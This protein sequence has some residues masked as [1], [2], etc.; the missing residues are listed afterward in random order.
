M[1]KLDIVNA[2]NVVE[3]NPQKAQFYIKNLGGPKGA[4]GDKGDPGAGLRIT[5]TVATYE[6]LPTNLVY[7]DAGEAYFVREDGKLYIWTG[8]DWPAKG[9][10]SNFEGPQGEQGVPGRNGT[11][12]KDGTDGF[13]PVATV[14]QVGAG[15]RISITDKNGTTTADVAGFVVDDS[16]SNSSTNP[17]QN[18]V[19]KGAL[20]G[21]QDTLGA[22]DITTNLVANEAIISSKIDW[23]TIVSSNF[24]ALKANSQGWQVLQ[25]AGIV[26]CWKESSQSSN[27]WKDFGQIP[28]Q[29]SGKSLVFFQWTSVFG[30]NATGYS[31]AAQVS[32]SN[33]FA[34]VQGITAVNGGNAF[35]IFA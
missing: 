26:F 21:K 9:E 27:G 34:Q 11:D 32:G 7:N 12:G 6:D 18:K 31:A 22:G 23:S 20:D 4:K 5:G 29:A 13:S 10:G 30:N 1:P 14:A 25:I 33:I 8:Y 28:D 3:F 35:A 19:V 15:A 16:L 17:V 2:N 24:D